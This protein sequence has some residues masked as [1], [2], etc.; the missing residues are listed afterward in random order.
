VKI[1]DVAQRSGF[2]P[3]TLRY[4]EE[5]GLLPEPRRTSSGYR[6]YDERTLDRLAFIARAKELGCTLEE[7]ADLTT[8]WDGGRCGPI[9]DRLRALVAAKT[10]GA[11]RRIVEL[12]TLTVELQRAAA[13]LEQ[14]RPEG[15]CDDRCGCITDPVPPA[16]Q[17]VAHPLAL[18]RAVAPSPTE[19]P[20]ACTLGPDELGRQLD[21]WRALLAHAVARV[22]L[23]DGVRVELDAAT[24]LDELVRLVSAEQGCCAFLRFAITVDARGVGL[25]V[26]G[27]DDARPVIE[28]LVGAPAIDGSRSGDARL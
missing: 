5:I 6:A 4:Y 25:E 18:G 16:A 8:A 26:R 24:P 3:H 12:S 1:K 13:A 27:T 20:I 7:I 28:A 14:H 22:A 23:D 9:Q 21:D 2:S 15:A 10:A 11:R 19:A 17:V